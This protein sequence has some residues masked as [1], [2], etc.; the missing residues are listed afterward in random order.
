[1]SET[2]KDGDSVE[3]AQS[4]YSVASVLLRLEGS[5]LHTL[6]TSNEITDEDTIRGYAIRKAMGENPG[7]VVISVLCRVIPEPSA[8]VDRTAGENQGVST[9]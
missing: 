4:T 3:F 7:S 6:F 9:C 2:N 5:L 8:P 1:M